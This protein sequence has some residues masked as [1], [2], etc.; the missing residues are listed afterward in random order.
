MNSSKK[1]K[2]IS[3]ITLCLNSEDTISETLVS[4]S[5]QDYSLIEHIIIDGCSSDSTQEIINEYSKN[6]KHE[7]RLFT[8]KPNGIYNALNYGVSLS[9]GD[10]IGVIHSDDYF[11]AHSSITDIMYEFGDT[12]LCVFGNIDILNKN[13][14]IIRRWKDDYKVENRGHWWAPPHTA[15]YL[16]KCLFNKYGSYDE[17][18][19]ISGDYDFFCRLPREVIKNFRHLDKTLVN[20]RMG[21]ISTS[22]GNSLKKNLE[23]LKV[24]R[25]Y[26]KKP[27]RDFIKK[28]FSKIRQFNYN[29]LDSER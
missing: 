15:T 25:K 3:L 2:K 10:V 8:H 16:H 11:S 4:V 17:E 12:T 27:I 19:S 22:F 21:G 14:R 9:T 1:N 23:D 28:K 24:L 20:Q 6:S 26:S 5:I 7:V 18:Y 29:L 13:K